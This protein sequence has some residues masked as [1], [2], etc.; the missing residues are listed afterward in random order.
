[1][2]GA[3]P[4]VHGV[5]LAPLLGAGR[6]PDKA[7]TGANGADEAHPQ[8]GRQAEPERSERL[9]RSPA[10]ADHAAAGRHTARPSSGGGHRRLG[11]PGHRRE[12]RRAVDREP[13]TADRTPA[14]AGRRPA[15]ALDGATVR[16]F[17]DRAGDMRL[18]RSR[19]TRAESGPLPRPTWPPGTSLRPRSTRSRCPARG[20]A[21]GRADAG[22][23]AAR[24]PGATRSATGGQP[25]TPATSEPRRDTTA[26]NASR[27]RAHHEHH[28]HDDDTLDVTLDH[29]SRSRYLALTSAPRLPRARPLTAFLS[30]PTPLLI[31]IARPPPACRRPASGPPAICLGCPARFLWQVEEGGSSAKRWTPLPRKPRRRAKSGPEAGRRPVDLL[32]INS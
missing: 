8:G 20:R 26:S 10:G 14:I 9:A 27:R 29:A 31:L 30:S 23:H 22:A 3:G 21:A 2:A 1:M 6:V 32:R 19:A 12:P 16:S 7:A 4:A 15:G 25:G 28:E 18:Y 13:R 5:L 17:D 24:R 11:R